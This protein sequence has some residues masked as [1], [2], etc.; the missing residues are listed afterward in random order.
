MPL[1]WVQMIPPAWRAFFM[2]SKNF[3]WKREAAGPRSCV[4]NDA[5]ETCRSY[6]SI[7]CVEKEQR[8]LTNWVRRVSDDNIKAVDLVLEECEAI[9][10]VDLD[11]GVL[12]A[13]GHAWQVL[14]RHANDSLYHT[15]THTHRHTHTHISC[16]KPG[17]STLKKIQDV[18][19]PYFDSFFRLLVRLQRSFAL[20][21]QSMAV[22]E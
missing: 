20:L 11:L 18:H 19:G 17:L 15:H 8:R 22:T 9:A 10:D 5:L 13:S 1:H 2:S 12:K 4:V 14:L 3:A 7:P 21:P 6:F 16:E